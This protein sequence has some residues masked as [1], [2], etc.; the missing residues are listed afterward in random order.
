MN[1][2]ITIN[3]FTIHQDK[4]GR[5]NLND[6][7]KAAVASGIKKD[8]RPSEWLSL[9]STHELIEI[10][11][12][13][14]SLIKPVAISPGRYGGTFGL[15]ELV[16]AYATWVSAA[17]HLKVIRTFDAVVMGRME[18]QQARQ[19]GKETRRG[20]TDTIQRFISYSIAQGSQHPQMHYLSLTKMV[21]GALELI[22][23]TDDGFRDTL[24]TLQHTQ[25]AVL[26]HAAR[27]AIHEGMEEGLHYKAIFQKAKQACLTLA[28]SLLKY[29]GRDSYD[30]LECRGQA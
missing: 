24:S 10:L 12:Q 18:W 9:Q 17:F 2:I 5:Y 23:S 1:Q 4:Q 16:Y 11:I 3:G 8:V 14:N 15:K 19:L 30:A 25:L 26:E 7:H 27:Q 29:T 22:K 20:F 28:E 6:L 21:Y 13:E